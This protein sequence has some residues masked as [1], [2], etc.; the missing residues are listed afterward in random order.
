MRVFVWTLILNAVAIGAYSTTITNWLPNPGPNTSQFAYTNILNYDN[1]S[2]AYCDAFGKCF[3]YRDAFGGAFSSIEPGDFV[4]NDSGQT[5]YTLSFQ[6]NDVITVYGFRIFLTDDSSLNFT[7]RDRSA[8]T[9]SFSVGGNTVMSSPLATMGESYEQTFASSFTS[10]SKV[11]LVDYFGPHTGSSF[12]F[13]FT[14]NNETADNGIRIVEIQS[15]DE[16][17]EPASMF[18]AVVGLCTV[19]LA[20]RKARPCG[21]L[22]IRS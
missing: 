5:T 9:I 13:Q 2:P 14:S 10:A 21:P 20:A 19:A 1:S 4:F 17:P 18:L 7:D 16:I 11:T 12:S 8:T 6:T 15:L 3:D 22:A